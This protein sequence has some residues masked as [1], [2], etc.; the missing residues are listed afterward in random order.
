M[1]MLAQINSASINE[2][3]DVVCRSNMHEAGISTRELD[4]HSWDCFASKFK[5]VIHEQTSCFNRSRNKADDLKHIAV[6]RNQ[7][8]IGGALAKLFR[9][10]GIS[11]KVAII[12]W[13]PLWRPLEA[14]DSI[15]NLRS[16][17]QAVRNLLT[18]THNCF[19]LVIPKADPSYSVNE[20]AALAQLGFTPSYQPESP[21]RY[22][23][24]VDQPC[25]EIKA[26]F[27]QKWRYNLKK[28]AQS[29][30]RIDFL[31]EDKGLPLFMELYDSMVERKNFLETSPIDTLQDLLHSGIEALRPKIVIAS[32]GETPVAGAILDCSGERAIYLYGATNHEALGLR[33]GYAIHWEIIKYLASVPHIRWY[34]LGGGTSKNCSLHQFKRGMVGKTGEVTSVPN[35]HYFSSNLGQVLLG[36]SLLNLELSK[37]RI[38]KALHE[39]RFG[40]LGK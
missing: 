32:R 17:Y 9:V 19:V 24:N 11:V 29:N 16:V 38:H 8:P 20:K 15:H 18:H 22:F 4:G 5:D 26:S 27:T 33:A 36:K 34:D 37:S 31:E 3:Q 23:V 39:N 25:E 10:P 7:K 1:N 30:L 6:F 28:S 12:R 14:E 21:E 40:F 35:Y 2:T 13:G